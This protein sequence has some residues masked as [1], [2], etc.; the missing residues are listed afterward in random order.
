LQTLLAERDK[1]I[2]GMKEERDDLDSSIETLRKALKEQETSS[3]MP[4]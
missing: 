4:F 3:G 2:Q 1:A